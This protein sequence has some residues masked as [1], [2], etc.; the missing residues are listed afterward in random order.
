MNTYPLT[1]EPNLN[2]IVTST[3]FFNK[4]VFLE[5]KYTLSRFH[6]QLKNA[7]GILIFQKMIFFFAFNQGHLMEF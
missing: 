7:N 3:C 4:H 6:I 5:C 2:P 1:V